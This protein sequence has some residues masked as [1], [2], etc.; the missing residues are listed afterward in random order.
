MKEPDLEITKEKENGITRF[1][2]KGRISLTT[3]PTMQ[4]KLDEAMKNGE[5][6]IVLNMLQVSFLS[7]AGIRIILK[8]HKKATEN[9]GSFGIEDPS[10]NVRNVLG[11]TALDELLI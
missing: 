11:M 1:I 9:G 3:A 8:T 6:K 10:E 2:L 4:F 5:M 7:S